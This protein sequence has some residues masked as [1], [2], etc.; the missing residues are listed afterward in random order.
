MK[1]NR[2]PWNV[3]DALTA[4]LVISGASFLAGS[5]VLPLLNG[6]QA[7]VKAQFILGGTIQTLLIFLVLYYYL[8]LKYS[9]SF[10]QIGYLCKP[11]ARTFLTAFRW[12]VGIFVVVIL[13]GTVIDRLVPGQPQLQPFAKLVLEA[14][15]GRDLLLPLFLAV[16]IAPLGEESFFRG[17]LYPALKQ[18]IGLTGGLIV[19]GVIFGLMH[20]DLLRLVPLSLGGIGLAWLYE[21]T[22]TIYA[23]IVAH[24]VWNGIMVLMLFAAAKG[25]G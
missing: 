2:V 24:G 21:R 3:A 17:F 6:F 15:N 25:V 19:A 12:G 1:D 23:P 13:S 22:G 4:L 18:R 9:G 10:K 20:F 11:F 7:G 14:E 16:I 8:V 5:V